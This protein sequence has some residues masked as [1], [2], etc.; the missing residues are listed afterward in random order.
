MVGRSGWVGSSPSDL[1]GFGALRGPRTRW[2]SEL[3]WDFG[4]VAL[5]V[6]FGGLEEAVG[7]VCF[8]YFVESQYLRTFRRKNARYFPGH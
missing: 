4:G 7:F 3:V 2:L 8:F 6:L 1:D 5:V